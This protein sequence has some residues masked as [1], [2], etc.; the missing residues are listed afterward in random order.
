MQVNAKFKEDF[1][2]SAVINENGPVR[3]VVSVSGGGWI[4]MEV[5]TPNP[6][7]WLFHC[8][9]SQHSHDGMSVQRVQIQNVVNRLAF[10]EF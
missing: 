9:I 2:L 6:G 8:H 10:T 7:F 3:D 4:L 1:D 5:E